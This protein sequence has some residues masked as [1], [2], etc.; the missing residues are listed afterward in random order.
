MKRNP[1][2]AYDKDGRAIQPAT[3]ASQLV[4]GRKNVEIY[5]NSCGRHRGGI[6]V[7]ELP[8]ETPIPDICLHYRCSACGS[9]NLMRSCSA[10]K[11]EPM[12]GAELAHAA[13]R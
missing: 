12:T 6:D 9:K 3:V 10:R 13:A 11:P 5:C 8:P 7:S 2:R 1:R 4:L